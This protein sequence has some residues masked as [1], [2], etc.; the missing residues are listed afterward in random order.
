MDLKKWFTNHKWI[1]LVLVYFIALYFQY[2]T[3][4]W[5]VFKTA[6]GIG[7]ILALLT[8][9]FTNSK[10]LKKLI[11]RIKFFFGFGIFKWE[12]QAVFNVR[13]SKFSSL[14]KEEIN[15]TEILKEALKEKNENITSDSIQPSYDKIGNLKLLVDKYVAYFDISYTDLEEED[16]DGFRLKTLSINTKASLR[17]KDNNKAIN[18]LLLDFYYNIEQKY[19][20]VNQKYTITI[21]PEDFEKNYMKKQFINELTP[22]EFSTFNIN[23][24]TQRVYENINEKNINFV[25]NRREDLNNLIKSA[26]LKLS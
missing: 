17:Y 24:S 26:I 14:K 5:G 1:V 13:I 3:Y 9:L 2:R 12:A 19:N 22:D 15:I 8:T 6:A 21:T 7:L 20:P 11:R 23:N 18:G 25:T 10:N 4:Q 16:D